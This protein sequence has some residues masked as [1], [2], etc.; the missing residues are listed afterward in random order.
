MAGLVRT[1]VG[2]PGRTRPQMNPA[3]PTKTGACANKYLHIK[4]FLR[5]GE[6][7][8]EPATARPQPDFSARS[9]EEHK[10]APLM[11]AAPGLPHELLDGDV[12]IALTTEERRARHLAKRSERDGRPKP[13]VRRA[14]KRSRRCTPC[15]EPGSPGLRRSALALTARTDEACAAASPNTNGCRE[16]AAIR[17]I[18]TGAGSTTCLCG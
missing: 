8:V 2:L 1:I 11:L 14:S 10:Q 6:T 15:C 7:G 5:I 16:S 12:L 18:A 4:H 13:Q 3:D 17:R 9:D